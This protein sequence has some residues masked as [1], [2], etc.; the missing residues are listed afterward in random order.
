MLTTIKNLVSCFG[1][2]KSLGELYSQI[3][4]TVHEVETPGVDGATK[5]QA[6][7]TALQALI[8]EGA[9][10][11]KLTL[12]V[13]AIMTTVSNLVDVAVSGRKHAREVYALKCGGGHG[14]SGSRS[15]S[16]S[17]GPSSSYCHCHSEHIVAISANGHS[18]RRRGKL[19]SY[20]G[21]G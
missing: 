18:S 17:V 12:P 20:S 2:V 11:L 14:D 16:G 1:L 21:R 9:S 3:V 15:R 10:L 6:A 19:R 4:T 13:S 8:T 7:L 5:K